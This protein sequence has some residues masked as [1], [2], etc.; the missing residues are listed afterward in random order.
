V[1]NAEASVA[2][3]LDVL[4]A[5]P[6]GVPLDQLSAGELIAKTLASGPRGETATYTNGTA[7]PE[8][9]VEQFLANAEKWKKMREEAERLTDELHRHERGLVFALLSRP[10]VPVS[11]V[12]RAWRIHATEELVALARKHGLIDAPAKK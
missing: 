5:V 10:G 8:F 7:L 3:N 11:E 9:D 2:I 4:T 1:A 6:N 12:L